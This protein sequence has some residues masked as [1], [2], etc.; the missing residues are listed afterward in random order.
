M[1]VKYTLKNA[2]GEEQKMFDAYSD[3]MYRKIQTVLNVN[4]KA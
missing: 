1:C 3:M 4:K 2:T